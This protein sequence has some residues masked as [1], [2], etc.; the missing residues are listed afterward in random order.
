MPS[1]EM[2]KSPP[3][4]PSHDSGGQAPPDDPPCG[5]LLNAQRQPATQP[6]GLSSGKPS[7]PGTRDGGPEDG[8]EDFSGSLLR[9]Q[10]S[11]SPMDAIISL[12]S[13]SFF[14]TMFR[15]LSDPDG[16]VSHYDLVTKLINSQ[17]FG[18]G[19]GC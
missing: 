18:R 17:K 13:R 14:K 8:P 15:G 3:D 1:E 5:G 12:S 7:R 9:K 11:D 19:G 10:N 4:R 16:R 6:D 2:A